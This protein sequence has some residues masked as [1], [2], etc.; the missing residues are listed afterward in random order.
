MAG[1]RLCFGGETEKG[2]GNHELNGCKGGK[3]NDDGMVDNVIGELFTII[4]LTSGSHRS[5]DSRTTHKARMLSGFWI[6]MEA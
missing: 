5:R 1:T 3:K 4:A 6:A 2:T